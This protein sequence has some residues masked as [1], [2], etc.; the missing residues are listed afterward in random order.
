MYVNWFLNGFRHK[1]KNQWTLCFIWSWITSLWVRHRSKSRLT[2]YE[3]ELSHQVKRYSLNLMNVISYFKEHQAT[4][5][6]FYNAYFLWVRGFILF[7][8]C[9]LLIL[10]F[11]Q[12]YSKYLKSRNSSNAVSVHKSYYSIPLFHPFYTPFTPVLKHYFQKTFII[13]T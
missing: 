7:N 1:K 5:H 12:L 2:S 4:L 13:L 11:K 10:C 6:K 8:S 9:S 3:K